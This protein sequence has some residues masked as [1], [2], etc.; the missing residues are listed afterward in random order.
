LFSAFKVLFASPPPLLGSLQ[1]GE[2]PEKAS[3]AVC[4]LGL[5]SQS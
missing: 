2:N 1:S 3:I 4:G 5:P